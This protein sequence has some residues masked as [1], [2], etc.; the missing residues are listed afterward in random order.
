ML[1][2]SPKRVPNQ[3][4]PALC[5][6]GDLE[7]IAAR[8]APRSWARHL[9]VLCAAILV[10][11]LHGASAV[12][13][14][15]ARRGE[16]ATDQG[17]TVVNRGEGVDHRGVDWST[18]VDSTWGPGLPT[19]DKLAIFDNAVSTIRTQFA[20]YQGL[21]LDFDSLTTAFRS[22]V[23]SGVSRGRFAAIMNR[24]S[25]AMQEGH[26]FIG[27][28]VVNTETAPTP[29]IPL[30][31]LDGWSDVSHFGAGLT[32]L[33][34]ESL[35]VFKTV[36]DHPLGLVPGDKV[37]G[38]DGV[39]WPALFEELW[40]AELPI[41]FSFPV[42]TSPESR[43][44]SQLM[45]AGLN[46][47]L[48]E[49][50]DVVKHSTGDTLHLSTSPLS[51]LEG[52]LWGDERLAVPGIPPPDYARPVFE[53]I[54]RPITWGIIEGTDIAYLEASAW[55]GSAGTQFLAAV[56]SLLHHVPNSGLV[57][58]FRLNYGG[59]NLSSYP[60]LE[61]LFNE[62]VQTVGW[63]IRCGD[64][65]DW[66]EMCPNPSRTITAYTID[67][68]PETFYDKPIAMLLGPGC[69]SAGDQNAYR[70]S[71]HPSTRAFGKPSA[72]GHTAG[73]LVP[74]GD[75]DWFMIV[76]STTAYPVGEPGSYMHRVGV[77]VDEAVWLE[78]DDVAIGRDTVL[79]RAIDW[80]QA[81]TGVDDGLVDQ[82]DIGPSSGSIRAL[83]PRPNPF[84]STTVIPY[85]VVE[86]SYVALT[87]FDAS[88]RRVRS[89]IG[90]TRE[91]G[92]YEFEWDG[93]GNGG[94]KLTSGVY[95]YR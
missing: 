57:L 43:R 17:G 91:P 28:L 62:T 40:D 54:G 30:L 9:G 60:G 46:W 1:F 7:L 6:L 56:D 65:E 73:S 58:D 74:L 11:T 50:I 13:S 72:G 27:D 94:Q 68:D 51:T 88:G 95:Y 78:P 19:P 41:Y 90:E 61:L 3:E 10:T 47:H 15:S 86:A 82:G 8:P 75:P 34:D 39:R 31:F 93:R 32:P 26:T 23:E 33:E 66:F 44:H 35:L 64:P 85:E 77:P 37:L 89:A 69:F 36:P 22:E 42:G 21:S 16:S 87:I 38:Y 53:P 63:D 67:G 4:T 24:I 5:S 48:F 70:I 45:S 79:D 2:R 55:S 49:T 81:T 76:T 83:T 20:A 59:G 52:E 18:L 29:G 80:I 92:S 25:G 12:A 14:G 71:L 84:S